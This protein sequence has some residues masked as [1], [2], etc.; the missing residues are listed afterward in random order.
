MNSV[1]EHLVSF[2]IVNFKTEKL[3]CELIKSIKNY[4]TRYNYE[5]L[6]F[7]NSYYQD[8]ILYTIQDSNIH[9]FKVEK[10]IG[11][12]RAN[13]IL[14]N[15]CKG[16]IVV[17]LNSDTLLINDSLE[18]IFDYLITNDEI[19]IIGPKL[20]NSDLTYQESFYRFP[21]FITTI[22]ELIFLSKRAYSYN[23]DIEEI[24]NVDVIKGA[25]L[26]FKKD[27]LN[28]EVPFDESFE[29]Y[30][31]EVDFC[32]RIKKKRYKNIYYPLSQIIHIGGVSSNVDEKAKFYSNYNYYKS[33]RFFFKKHKNKFQ[34]FIYDALI[35]FSL[36]E[37]MLLFLFIF[38]I[39]KASFFLKILKNIYFH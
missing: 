9:F 11:F 13:N 1:S 7:D 4:I 22:K 26:V 37:R 31:E 19:G 28:G 18:K 3:V 2:L 21:S 5:I 24:H 35:F 14:F 30:S 39:S 17:L 12:V 32:Y 15:K 34:Y 25:C 8:S 23:F 6:I 27:I 38:R 20:L 36:I 29:M 10:N 33:K 16:N